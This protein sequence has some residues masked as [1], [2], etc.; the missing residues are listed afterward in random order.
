[1]TQVLH[2]N[3]L[4]FKNLLDYLYTVEN[5]LIYKEHVSVLQ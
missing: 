3:A 1:M 5:I 4:I 2:A